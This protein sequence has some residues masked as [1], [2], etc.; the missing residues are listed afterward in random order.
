MCADE[1]RTP[2]TGIL[3]ITSLLKEEILASQ[4][5][6]RKYAERHLGDAESSSES[7]GSANASPVIPSDRRLKLPNVAF[8]NSAALASTVTS[9]PQ[10]SDFAVSSSASTL[11]TVNVSQ[12][13]TPSRTNGV[14]VQANGSGNGNGTGNGGHDVLRLSPV[15]ARLRHA[16]YRPNSPKEGS[17][18]IQLI[19]TLSL[20][21]ESLLSIANAVLDISKIEA[22]AIVL[23]VS[24]PSF[25]SV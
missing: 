13:Q 23:R 3:G 21:T 2:L 8:Q 20:C 17:D 1:L 18:T 11:G 7:S 4:Q 6:D 9:Q 22:G 16:H 10:D 12:N 5:F 19:N 25:W 14:A 15:S 24:K